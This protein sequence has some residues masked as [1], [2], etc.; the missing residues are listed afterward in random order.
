M[1]R[2][3]ALRLRSP[4]LFASRNEQNRGLRFPGSNRLVD[5]VDGGIDLVAFGAARVIRAA[6][7]KKGEGAVEIENDAWPQSRLGPVRRRC[8]R[9]GSHD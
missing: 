5:E 4:A 3:P 7:A 9:C 6:I 2:E 1:L 8:V